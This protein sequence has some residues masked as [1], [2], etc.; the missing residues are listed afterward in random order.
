MTFSLAEAQPDWR[1]WKPLRVC[2]GG[3]PCAT[4]RPSGF[5]FSGFTSLPRNEPP[6]VNKILPFGIEGRWRKAWW[7]ADKPPAGGVLRR[8]GVHL[9]PGLRGGLD[10]AR[11]FSVNFALASAWSA[12]TL[13]GHRLGMN[14]HPDD[15]CATRQ[16]LLERLKRLDDDGAWR[17]FFETYWELIYNVARKAGL[18][19]AEA[20]EV[21]QDT[22]IVVA[23]KIGELDTDPGRGSFK[24]WL[25][26]QARWRIGDRFRARQ[27]ASRV[28][29]NRPA[30][31]AGREEATRTTPPE[32]S[33]CTGWRIQ[34][35]IRSRPCGR[36]SGN[37]A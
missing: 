37:N 2:A 31:R 7:G 17:D 4:F 35:A 23:R 19:D 25:L 11:G 28:F 9:E 30:R 26:G 33:R 29:Q 20:Q 21:V 18:N 1:Q 5:E 15:S 3:K 8:A 10:A 12:R 22:V 32:Q 14:L 24:S 27:R 16:S 34:A 13:C 36:S 6:N